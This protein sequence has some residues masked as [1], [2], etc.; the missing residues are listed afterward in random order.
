MRI[1]NGDTQ[2]PQM[3]EATGAWLVLIT[4][5]AC[6]EYYNQAQRHSHTVHVIYSQAVTE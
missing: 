4:R 2:T 1:H 6:I 3:Q 5:T